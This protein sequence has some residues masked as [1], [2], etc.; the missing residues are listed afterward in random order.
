M[1]KK[2][3]FSV[4]I[5]SFGL[6]LLK[7]QQVNAAACATGETSQCLT[8]QFPVQNA[9]DAVG[10]A[11]NEQLCTSKSTGS[12][13]YYAIFFGTNCGSGEFLCCGKT[14]ASASAAA[15][16]QCATGTCG[17]AQTGCVD[18][19][20]SL[21]AQCNQAYPGQCLNMSSYLGA[22]AADCVTRNQASLAGG[23]CNNITNGSHYGACAAAMA[24]YVESN[25]P[26]GAEEEEEEEDGTG[27]GI[28]IPDN[29]GLPD[30]EGG[31]AT[32]LSKL[33]TWLLGIVGTIALI[34][35]IIAGIQYLVSTGDEDMIKRAKQNMTYSIVGVIVALA[36]FVVLQAV[37]FML[38]GEMF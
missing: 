30:P 18:D 11:Q 8:Q 21:S 29:T 19:F 33:L 26:P 28:Y 13:N 1:N 27:N 7:V 34:S 20:P 16:S 2:L 12:I 24:S 10:L 38:R 17:S 15:P 23:N 36:G 14:I 37:D 3:I 9:Q 32:I 5:L 22:L 31:I 4:I 25:P 35:F 6:L